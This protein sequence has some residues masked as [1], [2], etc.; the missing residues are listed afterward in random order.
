VRRELVAQEVK[1]VTE[2]TVVLMAPVHSR[3]ELTEL[4]VLVVLVVQAA[5]ARLT[6]LLAGMDVLAVIGMQRGKE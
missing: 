5:L 6:A 4:V 2:V 3:M 1:A